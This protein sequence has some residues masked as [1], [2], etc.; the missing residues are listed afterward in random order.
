M[1][2]SLLYDSRRRATAADIQDI[3]DGAQGRNEM[4]QVIWRADRDQRTVRS[5]SGRV[6]RRHR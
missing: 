2:S 4:V 1:D 5:N 3:V 6:A